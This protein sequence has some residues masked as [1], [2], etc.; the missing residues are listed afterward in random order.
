MKIFMDA[1]KRFELEYG[2]HRRN[3][4]TLQ[5]LMGDPIRGRGDLDNLEQGSA[6]LFWGLMLI[7]FCVHF[8]FYN[9]QFLSLVL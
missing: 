7:L 4:L 9:H 3:G 8:V 5:T 2:Y 6:A 1:K